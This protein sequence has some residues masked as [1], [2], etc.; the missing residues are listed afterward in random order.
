[1]TILIVEDEKSVGMLI[2]E[3]IQFLFSKFPNSEIRL[4]TTWNEAVRI[5]QAAPSP[6]ISL[7]DLSLPAQDFESTISKLDEIDNYSPVVI[8]SGHPKDQILQLLQNKE[9]LVIEKGENNWL[10]R[11]VVAIIETLHIRNLSRYK[12]IEAKIEILKSMQRNA[13]TN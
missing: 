1:M 11:L 6:D 5:A 8:V 9:I 10:D 12:R 4:V 7:V 2:Q 3:R 13:S